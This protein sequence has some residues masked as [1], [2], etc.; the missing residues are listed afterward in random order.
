[1]AMDYDELARLI[2]AMTYKTKIYKVLRDE[3]SKQGHWRNKPRGKYEK[4]KMN[5]K[6]SVD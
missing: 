4:G 6:K 5:T 3:L 1:M 2:R